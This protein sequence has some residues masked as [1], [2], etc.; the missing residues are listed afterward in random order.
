LE[1]ERR[2][3]INELENK[4]RERDSAIATLELELCRKI[5]KLAETDSEKKKL[6][7]ALRDQANER[8][9]GDHYGR[10]EG[11]QKQLPEGI[12]ATTE[13]EAILPH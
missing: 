11:L 8:V 9:E 2:D 4:I 5:R 3:Q 10:N 12:R 1:S 7:S 13:L 6:Q